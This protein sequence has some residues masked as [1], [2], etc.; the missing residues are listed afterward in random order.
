MCKWK[1]YKE[2]YSDHH[3]DKSLYP[4]CKV[5]ITNEE[6]ILLSN[7]LIKVINIDEEL[8]DILDRVI[9]GDKKSYT[10]EN[11]EICYTNRGDPYMKGV[12][13]RSKEINYEVFIKFSDLEQVL[14][15]REM[16][17]NVYR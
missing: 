13:I 1:E 16:E 5:I 3:Y 7:R 11:I 4:K 15:E 8:L 12:G 2:L 14:E 6:L 9:K 17:I 10:K